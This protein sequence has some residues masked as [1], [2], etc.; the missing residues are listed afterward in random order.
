M[1]MEQ[2]YIAR[3]FV[4]PDFSTRGRGEEDEV[5]ISSRSETQTAFFSCSMSPKKRAI[6]EKTGEMAL[7][8]ELSSFASSSAK[9]RWNY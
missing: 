6:P 7:T 5:E 2:M 3:I 8:S 9:K 4:P 1:M